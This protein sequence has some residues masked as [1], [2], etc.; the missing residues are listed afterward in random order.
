ML[1]YNATLKYHN[2]FTL[3]KIKKSIG[4]NHRT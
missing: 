1:L 3:N 2:A 4:L